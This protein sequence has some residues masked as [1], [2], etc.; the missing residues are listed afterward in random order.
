MPRKPGVYLT[1]YG[2]AAEVEDWS[3]EFAYDLDMAED[4]PMSMVTSEFVRD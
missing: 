2:N 4:I 3:D 1:I